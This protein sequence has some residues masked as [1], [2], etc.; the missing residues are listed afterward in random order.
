M[1]LVRPQSWLGPVM[2]VGVAGALLTDRVLAAEEPQALLAFTEMLPETKT[3]L[4]MLTV[5]LL[6]VE[7]PVMPAGNVQV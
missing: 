2:L 4:L 6:V 5:M 1:A 7:V 3:E